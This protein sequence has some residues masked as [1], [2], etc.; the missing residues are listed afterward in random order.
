[1]SK[2]LVFVH[3]AGKFMSN[4]ADATLG[5][6]ALLLGAEP[7]SYPVYYADLYNVGSPVKVG[8]LSVDL[9]APAAEPPEVT[10]FKTAF[11]MQVQSDVDMK[12]TNDKTLSAA[13]APSAGLTV[14]ALSLSP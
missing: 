14:S 9:A 13:P 3:G 10:Q 8:P 12:A 7:P 2:V 1:M 6:I 4:Y 5:E 11:M